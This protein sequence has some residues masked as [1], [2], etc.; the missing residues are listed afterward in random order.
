[1]P[2]KFQEFLRKKTEGSAW[3]ERKERR[4]EWL[5]A[6]N[7]LFAEIRAFL[8]EADPEGLIETVDYEVERVEERLG[9][10]NAPALRVRL[11]TASADFIPMGL[12][13]RKPLSLEN[14]LG[15]PGNRSRWGD[16][17]GGRVDITDGERKH[18]LFRSI[19]DG[20]DHW[21]VMTAERTGLIPFDRQSLEEILQDLLS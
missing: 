8:R 21:Y 11:N 19:Q 14:L 10:Y 7:R 15:V 16:L 20:Q 2:T 13:L 3:K 6:L 4:G 5:G 17:A 12:N 1:M 18:I 9:V